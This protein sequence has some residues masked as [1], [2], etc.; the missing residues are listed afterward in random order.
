MTRLGFSALAI[1]LLFSLAACGESHSTDDDSGI[2]FDADTPD[3]GDADAGDATPPDTSVPI[4][5][6]DGRLSPGE[7][8]DDGN[9]MDGDGCDSMCFREARCGDNAL[10][11]GEVCDDG[12]NASGDGCRSDCASDETC[13]NGI[14]DIPAGE[15]CDDGNTMDGDGCSADCRV[16][17][18]CGDGV[19]DTAAGE[20]CDD[21]NTDPWDGCAADCHIEISMVIDSLMVAGMG[22]GCDYSGDGVPDNKFGEGIGAV[23][24]AVGGG[25]GNLADNLTVLL[26]MR[27]LDDIHGIDDPDVT[28]AWLP[29]METSTPG[30]YLADESFFDMDGN[31]TVTFE[32]SIDMRMYA[33]GPE[34]ITIPVFI[35]PLEIRQSRLAGTT[36]ETGGQLSNIDDGLLCGAVPLD[37]LAAFPVPDGIPIVGGM[38]ACEGD[39]PPSFADLIVG[40]A[41]VL[42]PTP[43][44]VDLDGDGLEA[45]EVTRGAGCQPVVTACIDGDGTRIEGRDCLLDPHIRDGLSAAFP[46]TAAPATIVGTAAMMMMGP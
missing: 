24:G 44:D 40:G 23:L 19:L 21:G 39:A 20:Q 16:L 26:N 6:G 37:L 4:V 3:G 7:S 14:R 31:P 11:P 12:N 34:D 27:G 2:S 32:G 5:C 35:L 42:P 1:A 41:V 38:P 22:V 33:A 46:F 9:T 18:G 8:C 28:A 15:V 13:G 43:P 25:G 45:F 10:D 17:E 29:G 36:R 30:E